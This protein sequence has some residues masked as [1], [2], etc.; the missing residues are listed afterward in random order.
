MPSEASQSC[1]LV[2]QSPGLRITYIS[3]FLSGAEIGFLL[4]VLFKPVTI[5]SVVCGM[6]APIFLTQ[7]AMLL[8]A[9]FLGKPGLKIGTRAFLPVLA[10]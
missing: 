2:V 9:D 8:K 4:S 7:V 5:M 10:L 6:C 3:A 1:R